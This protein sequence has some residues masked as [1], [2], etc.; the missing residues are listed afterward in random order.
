M[1]SENFT[2]KKS[3]RKPAALDISG[4]VY[5]KVPPQA[6]DL[7]A[8]ILGWIMLTPAAQSFERVYE[9]LKPE[10]FYLDAHQR[11]FS[12]MVDLAGKS[13]PIDSATVCN[14]LREREEL[15][16]VGGPY[17][18]ATLSN[19]VVSDRIEHDC[20]IVQ[21][22]YLKRK[23]IMIC[24]ESM[25][26]AY[27]DS[28]DPFELLDEHDKAFTELTTGS[29]TTPYAHLESE[30]DKA[31]LRMDELRKQESH[32]TGI[33]SG[34]PSIDK[35]THGWQD[36]DLVILAA[37]PAVGKTA[38]ALNFARNAA[39]ATINPAW[40]LFFSLEMSKQQLTN[41]KISS[42]TEIWLDKI[43][44]GMLDEAQ[45]SSIWNNPRLKALKRAPIFIDDTAAISLLEIRAKVRRLYASMKKNPNYLNRKGLVIIDYLQLMSGS[46]DKKSNNREQEIST[47]SRGLKG[48]AKEI[49]IPIIA[50]SQL[51]REVEK[52]KGESKMP[53]LSDLRESG[54]IEQDADMVAFI[55]RPEYYNV[56]TDEMGESNTGET[57]IRIAKHRNGTLDTIKLRALLHIQK[58]VE[59]EESALPLVPIQKAKETWQSSFEN[60]QDRD[61]F[62]S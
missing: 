24:G 23:L 2:D 42:E 3:R 58:F 17:F 11:I 54:A 10:S 46:G 57:H 59:Y 12:A 53:Q 20:M 52:R 34:F 62:D 38:L 6:R 19:N 56:T 61:L 30:I 39:M 60:K 31:M 22:M 13:F 32:I 15:E 49:G 35:T 5:G 26:N 48:L 4:M 21:Q 33:P 16:L 9:F 45:M 37:R 43:S 47:I 8:A 40:V 25:S 44:H 29:I 36:T 28:M 41:R 1:R 27:E 14:R 50:L 55:Y 51:S 18:L 7:E